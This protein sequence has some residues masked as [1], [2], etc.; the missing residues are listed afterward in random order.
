M[1]WGQESSPDARV[2]QSLRV[3]HEERAQ[4]PELQR[5]DAVPLQPAAELPA[6]ETRD[7]RDHVRGARALP[8]PGLEPCRGCHLRGAEDSEHPLHL[9]RGGNL[10]RVGHFF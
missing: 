5:E 3:L 1:R 7:L 8:H 10:L 4:V 6:L 2:R 9:E